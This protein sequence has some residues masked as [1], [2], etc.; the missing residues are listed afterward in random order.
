MATWSVQV[1]VWLKPSVFD[2]QGNAVEHALGSL[3]KEGFYNV[4]IGKYMELQVEAGSEDE[5]DTKV[6]EVCDTVLCNPVMETYA[7]TISPAAEDAV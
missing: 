3:G 6:R 2:P 4:R 5:A 1:R 7:Y